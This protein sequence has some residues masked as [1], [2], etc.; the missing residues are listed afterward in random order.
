MPIHRATARH[1]AVG[2]S[3][4]TASLLPLA[5]AGCG[6]RDRAGAEPLVRD[7]AGVTIVENTAP[8]WTQKSAWHLSELPLAEIG[9]A[10]GDPEYQLFQV[11]G[12]MRL[13]NGRIVVAN[14]GTHELR[15]YDPYGRFLAAAGGKGDG[16]GEFQSVLLA[17]TLP[18][19]S[20]LALDWNARRVSIFDEEGR[21]R[22]ALPLPDLSAGGM[23]IPIVR[24]AFDDGSILVVGLRLFGAGPVKAGTSRGPAP[25][26]RLAPD[27]ARI[28][29]IGTFPGPEF[30]VRAAGSGFSVNQLP[31]GRTPVAAA[32]GE[33]FYYG[34][35][36]SYEIG[37]YSATG[38]LERII[39]RN[40][41]N[42]DVTPRDVDRYKGERL[43]NVKGDAERKR[44]EQEL[45]EIP[46]PATFAAYDELKLDPLGDLWVAEPFRPGADKRN[47]TVFD[48]A[49]RMLG[50]VEIPVRLSIQEIGTDY[51]LGIWKDD[52]DIEYVRLYGLNKPKE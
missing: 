46:F 19:D 41:K 11:T 51:V 20:L 44:L 23:V 43:A 14:G 30:Y 9:E 42:A 4:L 48:P 7:S 28:D 29:T 49:G 27:G 47:W 15:F 6:A 50:A 25:Y 13:P 31:F 5:L 39:R 22:R 37:V 8:L 32:K 17:G 36:D 18:G 34:A 12:A 40:A 21:F 24:G 52:S 16:P 33:R 1:R 10:E 2:L 35:S 38:S 26:L 3:C 45:A